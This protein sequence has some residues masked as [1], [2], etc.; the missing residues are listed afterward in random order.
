MRQF[1]NE[2]IASPYDGGLLGA[3]NVDIDEVIIGDTM[4]CSIAPL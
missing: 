1:R 4:L 2:I 3:R